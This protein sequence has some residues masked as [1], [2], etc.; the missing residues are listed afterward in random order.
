MKTARFVVVLVVLLLMP[1]SLVAA[2]HHKALSALPDLLDEDTNIEEE[3]E[4]PPEVP[5][6]DPLEPMNRFFFE[7]NDRLYFWVLKPVSK[8]YSWLLPEEL[9]ECIGSFFQNIGFPITFLNAALQA[10]GGKMLKATERFLINST[11]GVY[12]LVDVA[13]QEFGI[14]PQRAD[15]GQTLGRWGIGEGIYLCWPIVGPSNIR[16]SLGLAVDSV[17]NPLPYVYDDRII[18]LALYS[19]SKVNSLS[20]NPDLYEDLKRYSLDPYVASRQAYIEYRRGRLAQ[21]DN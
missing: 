15:F 14:P 6:Y 1:C 11:I 4:E 18:D 5:T 10:D 8:G 9:R 16:D 3:V 20:L 13:G 17:A 7:V 19:S 12:G 21:K 2:P